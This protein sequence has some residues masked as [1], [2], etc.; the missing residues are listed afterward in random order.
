MFET[1]TQPLTY[2]FSST[3]CPF[4]GRGPVNESPSGLRQH[5]HAGQPLSLP[6]A[7]GCSSTVK[8]TCVH[9]DT[10]EV[11]TTNIQIGDETSEWELS[12][13]DLLVLLLRGRDW[14][15]IPERNAYCQEDE[16]TSALMEALGLLIITPRC[17]PG[18]GH[19]AA[20][21]CTAEG[22]SHTTFYPFS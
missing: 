19:G 1:Q 21:E 9:G 16:E 13:G 7:V 4:A 15:G 14:L 18:W 20:E 2:Q 8:V 22:E 3:K 17:M 10:Q 5:H 11:V 12:V 6:L